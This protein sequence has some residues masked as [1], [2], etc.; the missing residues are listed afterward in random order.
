MKHRRTIF[1]GWL[2]TMLSLG[3]PAVCPADDLA[4]YIHQ[5]GPLKGSLKSD[6]PRPIFHA[7]AEHVWNRLFAALYIRPRMIAASDEQPKEMVRYEGGDVIE[8][9]AWGTTSYWAS[10]DAFAK[11]NPLLDEFLNGGGAD[12]ISD[13][14][15]RVVF[16]HDLWAVFDHLI[17]HNIQRLGNREIRT[18][19]DQLCAKLA[20][21]LRQLAVSSAV[22]ERLPHTYDVAVQSGAFAAAHHLDPAVNY[23]PHQL[24]NEKDPQEWVEID[25]YYPNM[26]EDIMDRFISLHARSFKGRSHY[27]IFYR[28]PEGRK[29]VTGYLQELEAKGIDWKNSAQFGFTHLR[30]DAPQIPV[31]TEVLLLQLM[32]TMDDQLRPVPTHLVESVQIRVFA[33]LDASNTPPTNTGVGVNVLDYRLHRRL[34]FD[35]LKAGGLHREPEGEPQYRVAVD[36]SKPGAPDWGYNDKTVLFQQCADCHMSRK[37][38]RLGVASIPSIVHSGGFDSGAMMGVAHP[39]DPPHS[40]LP[41]QRVAR[42]KQR[43]E[44]FRRLLEYLEQEKK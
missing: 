11:I 26:H 3:L 34:L 2:V 15:K 18:R 19:R 7:D 41:A 16:Q 43:D 28:F 24:L 33:N 31:G 30:A 32:M 39:L 37:L 12:M 4:D 9:L 1:C 13:P 5:Q 29:Q 35:N 10:S 27:R 21:C 6:A 44:T 8:F 36:G 22:I 17:D 38:E 40:N 14:L 23:L 42:Y 25:F 20:R